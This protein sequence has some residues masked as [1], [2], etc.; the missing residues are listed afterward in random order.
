MYPVEYHLEYVV[1]RRADPP[2]ANPNPHHVTGGMWQTS[3]ADPTSNHTTHRKGRSNPQPY[4]TTGGWNH[5]G[6]EGGV[7]SHRHQRIL[8]GSPSNPQPQHTT[9][10]STPVAAGGCCSQR[11][12]GSYT[13]PMHAINNKHNNDVGRVPVFININLY[14]KPYPPVA[15]VDYMPFYLKPQTP[16]SKAQAKP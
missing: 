5:W 8:L 15:L 2:Q 12:S 10:G 7:R 14:L 6:G 9:G 1:R 16:N 3:Q 11:G 4:H 13:S